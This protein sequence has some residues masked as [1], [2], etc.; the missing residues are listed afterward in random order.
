MTKALTTRS[1][2]QMKPDAKTRREIPDG[3]LTGLYLVVQPQATTGAKSWAVRYRHG[4]RPRKLTLGSYPALELAEAREAARDA[5]QAVA[6]GR[7]P[8]SQK[9]AARQEAKEGRDLFENVAAHFLARHA[10]GKRSRP[11][12]ER[13][14]NHDILPKWRGRR[15]QD[16]TRRDVVALLDGL[17]DRGIGTMTNRVFALIRKLFNWAL[18]RDI[19]A[20]SP[21]ANLRA[22]VE[23]KSRDRTLT[24]DELRWMW[25]ATGEIGYPFGPLVRLLAVTGQRRN[26]VAG[27]RR[28]EIK[29]G[30]WSIPVERV[31]NKRPHDVPL[32]DF[33]L[34]IMESLLKIV[35]VK[36]LVFTTNGET[37]VS[38]F[39]SFKA[40]LDKAMLALARKERGPDFE[41]PRWTL[42]DLRRTAATGLQRLN[43]PPHV[44][45]A[46]L[47]HRDG[48][49]RGVAAVYARHDY[50]GEKRIALEAWGR[51][52]AAIVEGHQNDNVVAFQAAASGPI[53]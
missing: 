5:L 48:I 18:S 39:S 38:G 50:A 28:P 33:A 15:I 34:D 12:M 11:E 7:D 21:C 31:K 24:D 13:M 42:H 27:M 30:L 16:I 49:I 9:A 20:A 46:I 43:I 29:D 1:V 45:E 17:Q 10:D 8:A 47:N 26:E 14:L 37:A 25:A 19:V 35:G 52:L 4:G 53:S 32:S 22:P 2:E 23:E 36:Q 44:T 41:L 6:K 3:L 40:S 51:R